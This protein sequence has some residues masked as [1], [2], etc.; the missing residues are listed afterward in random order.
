MC[1]PGLRIRHWKQMS[2][3]AK[4]DL[5]PDSSSTL[6]KVLRLN[7]APF[8]EQFEM[9]STSATKVRLT[10][11]LSC[12]VWQLKKNQSAEKEPVSWKR[13]SQLKMNQ[14]AEKNQSV[15]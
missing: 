1:N 14:S 8:M 6:R 11:S 5:M 10:C 9:I 12:S 13:T 2:D 3:I 15:S 7:I 4:F